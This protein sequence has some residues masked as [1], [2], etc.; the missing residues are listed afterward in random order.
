MIPYCPYIVR[1]A[2]LKVVYDLIMAVYFQLKWG[3]LYL[4]VLPTHIGV[5]P[6]YSEV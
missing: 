6:T 2:L 4:R 1:L 5:C 3:L